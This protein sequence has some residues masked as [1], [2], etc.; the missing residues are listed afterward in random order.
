MLKEH[1]YKAHSFVKSYFAEHFGAERHMCL[2]F[3]TYA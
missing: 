1:L 3:Y 2:K